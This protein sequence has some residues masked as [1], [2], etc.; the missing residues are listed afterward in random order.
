MKIDRTIQLV[1]ESDWE[2]WNTIVTHHLQTWA[3]GNFRKSMGIDMVRLGIYD[4][5]KLIEGW[6]LT[7]HKIPH[8]PFTIGYFPKGPV[9][10]QEMLETLVRVGRQHKAIFIQLEPNT[11]TDEPV[12][13]SSFPDIHH[14]HHPLFT[15]FTF[16]LDLTKSEDALLAS[17]HNKTRYN[18]RLAERKGVVIREDDSEKAFAAYLTLSEETT[19][20]QGFY[21]HNRRY[22]KVMWK[23]LHDAGIAKLF[24]ATFEGN[25]ITAWI[26][27]CWKDTVYYP[28]GASSRLHREVM[29]PN[30][31]LWEIAKWAKR[32]GYFYF[33]LWGAMGPNPDTSDPWYGFHRF[34]EGYHPDLVEFLGSFDLVIRKSWYRLYTVADSLRWA[35]L[36]RKAHG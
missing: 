7:F 16:V 2:K 32:Q 18:I 3:W 19:H 4:H 15:S 31:M 11:T 28:Y 26:I 10:S 6:Q 14:A 9:P 1:S 35:L 34:K 23:T 13:I 20:R 25:I 36:K 27:F 12:A 24:T 29:A 8:L 33:D 30:L 22:H 21:A 17:M 5:K